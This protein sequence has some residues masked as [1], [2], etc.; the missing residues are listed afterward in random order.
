MSMIYVS[1]TANSI[2]IDHLQRAGHQIHLIAPTN[3]TY[4]PVSAHPDIYLCGMGPGG[5]VFFGDPAK[6]GPRY[7]QN[8][9]Y[10]AAC[11]GAFFIHN[12]NYTDPKLLAQAESMEKIHV[13]QGYAKCN[14]VIVDETSIITADRGIYKACSGKLDVLLVDPGHVAL[15]GFPYGFLGGASGRVEDEIIFNGN[16]K[17]HP[18][19]EKIRSFIES[20]GL[21]VKYFSQYAL[22]DIGSIIQGAPAD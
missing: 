6:I 2:L 11:T 10:N 3:R 7:P 21:K 4:D 19:Y 13:R 12:L 17:S 5:P 16:L 20:R 9:V 8:I 18:D 22:E 15:Q 14:I 1:Q